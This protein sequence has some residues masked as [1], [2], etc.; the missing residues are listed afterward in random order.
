VKNF[1]LNWNLLCSNLCPLPHV[2]LLCTLKS[3]GYI[4]SLP[5]HYV[6]EGSD[7]TSSESSLVKAEQNHFCYPLLIYHVLYSLDLS[8]D[9]P[10][11]LLWF[12]Q[13]LLVLGIRKPD[14][15]LQMGV[16]QVMSKGPS[17]PLSCWT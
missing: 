17:L 5:S 13:C 4:I 7:T 11:D 3:S 8:G 10:Q 9:P 16:F 15:V 14:I 1:L 6:M 12:C 2:L